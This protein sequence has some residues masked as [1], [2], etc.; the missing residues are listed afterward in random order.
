MQQIKSGT[1]LLFLCTVCCVSMT[2][3]SL[4]GDS[5]TTGFRG[6]GLDKS[7]AEK[8]I[9]QYHLKQPKLFSDFLEQ[10]QPFDERGYDLPLD[11]LF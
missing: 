7:E 1:I 11:V 8:R 2:A 3:V 6:F 5:I 9:H 4:M 10:W